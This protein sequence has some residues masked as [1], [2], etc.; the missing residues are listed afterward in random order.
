MS[1]IKNWIELIHYITGHPESPEVRNIV[2]FA[3]KLVSQSVELR[4]VPKI[5]TLKNVAAMFFDNGEKERKEGAGRPAARFT[6]KFEGWTSDSPTADWKTTVSLKDGKTILR[7][8]QTQLKN[9]SISQEYY[10]ELQSRIS[11]IVQNNA[12]ILIGQFI[13]NVGGEKFYD[14]QYVFLSM[15]DNAPD[16]ISLNNGDDELVF[17]VAWSDKSSKGNPLPKNS[18][19]QIR[20]DIAGEFSIDNPEWATKEGQ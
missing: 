16:I 5:S 11:V 14:K 19:G 10:N 4:E 13:H 8:I 3:D 7:M 6:L 2:S 18:A 1:T 9:N 15:K 20:W 12:P 17:P